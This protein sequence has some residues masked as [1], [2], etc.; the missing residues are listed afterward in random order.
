MKI[1]FSDLISLENLKNLTTFSFKVPIIN[2]NKMKNF[3]KDFQPPNSLRKLSLKLTLLECWRNFASR[4][5]TAETQKL[6]KK[7]SFFSWLFRSSKRKSQS[8]YDMDNIF[9]KERIYKEFYERWN[10]LDKL[11]HLTLDIQSGKACADVHLLFI[12]PIL[13]QCRSLKNLAITTNCLTLFALQQN[14]PSIRDLHWEQVLDALEPL[15]STLESFS[16]ECCQIS[17]GQSQILNLKNLKRVEI[18]VKTVDPK[19]MFKFLSTISSESET[20]EPL[21]SFKVDRQN[22]KER[23]ELLSS[24]KFIPKNV[25]I[26]FQIG[27]WRMSLESLQRDLLNFVSAAQI[28]GGLHLDLEEPHSPSDLTRLTELIAKATN[29]SWP[30]RLS[31]SHSQLGR[32]FESKK[33]N[34]IFI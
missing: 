17:F 26:S 13:S 32:I 29:P 1:F 14:L 31:I 25:R 19:E 10:D 9:E 20:P 15:N 7:S 18:K 23:K 4:Y 34:R 12:T 6:Q 11:S 16:L 5:A 30:G 33:S 3:L 21:F 24:I 27:I 28:E 22:E 2:E 8:Q